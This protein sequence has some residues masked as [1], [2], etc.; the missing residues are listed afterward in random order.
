MHYHVIS[1]IVPNSYFYVPEIRVRFYICLGNNN[2]KLVSIVG[3][4][5]AKL[6]GLACKKHF[7]RNFRMGLMKTCF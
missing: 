5:K 2:N 1:G 7:L 6:I 3:P 4:A